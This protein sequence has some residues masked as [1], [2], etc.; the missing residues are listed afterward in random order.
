VDFVQGIV[1]LD[2]NL[3]GGRM[4]NRVRLYY[5]TMDQHLLQIQ[6]A[7]AEFV[8]VDPGGAISPDMQYW[9]HRTYKIGKDS[10][11]ANY[12]GSGVN[13]LLYDMPMCY[14][15]HAVQVDYLVERGVTLPLERVSNEMHI[16]KDLGLAYG[17][18]F[19]LNKPNVVGVQAVRGASMRVCGWW[20]NEQG[21]VS[22]VDT[23]SILFGG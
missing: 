1:T 21:R 13:T 18:G 6:K 23:T 8:E 16:I 4:G 19:V 3:V 14:E 17:F 9:L 5:K 22:R 20:R 15:G 2:P 7:P 12:T 11:A 10:G